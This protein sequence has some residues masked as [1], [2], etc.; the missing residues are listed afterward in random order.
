MVECFCEVFTCLIHQTLSELS[1]YVLERILAS[2]FYLK[3]NKH[4]TLSTIIGAR[5]TIYMV[6]PSFWI[7]FNSIL[8]KEPRVSL[9]LMRCFCCR[10]SLTVRQ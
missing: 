7:L 1:C 4:V 2:N 8:F 10:I 5:G 6:R 9:M 3:R